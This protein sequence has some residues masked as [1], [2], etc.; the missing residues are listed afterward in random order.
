MGVS[1]GDESCGSKGSGRG[2]WGGG[3]VNIMRSASVFI[4]IFWSLLSRTKIFKSWV[5]VLWI[6]LLRL[7]SRH[8]KNR[9]R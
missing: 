3:W 5:H 6:F 8:L 2:G 4:S 1:R 7:S 9:E